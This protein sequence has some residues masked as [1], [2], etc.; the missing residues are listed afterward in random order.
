MIHQATVSPKGAADQTF[1][2]QYRR[3]TDPA[4]IEQVGPQQYKLRVY[5]VPPKQNGNGKQKVRFSYVV[6]TANGKAQLPQITEQRNLFN[7]SETISKYRVDVDEQQLSLNAQELD[8]PCNTQLRSCD[9]GVEELITPVAK[10][11]YIPY[12]L[13]RSSN[14]NSELK[15]LNKLDELI[16]GKRVAV[17]AD[18]SGSVKQRD[19]SEFLNESLRLQKLLEDNTVDLYFFNEYVSQPIS[20]N[21]QKPPKQLSFG[22]TNRLQALQH[23]AGS[24]DLVLLFTDNSPADKPA[25]KTFLPSVSQPIYVIHDDEFGSGHSHVR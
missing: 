22:E 24:Y 1:E 25:E 23:I 19:W 14:A 2:A 11:Y 6:P 18:S 4:I 13:T 9:E 21:Q 7:N 3:R 5:P 8:V 16:S 20:L 15:D 17:L 12:S 10:T